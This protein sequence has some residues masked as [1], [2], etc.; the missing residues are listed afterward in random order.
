MELCKYIDHTLLRADAVP[1]E[2]ER[3]CREAVEHRFASVCVNGKYVPLAA[4][5]T[6]GT[7]VGVA[8]VVGFPLGAMASEAKA[9]EA[10]KAVRDGASE[11]DM[12][13]DIG[14][15]K[16][17]DFAA[18]ESDVRAVVRAA[19]G[20]A[21][22]KA[23]IETCLL[24]DDE[25]RAACRAAVAGG[26]AFVKT[27][28]GFSKGGATVEDVRLMREKVGPD[29]GVKASGGVRTR[30]AAEAMIAAGTTRIGTSS[31]A[32]ICEQANM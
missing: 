19:D 2:I 29:V 17:H 8:C 13:I 9:F 30:E 6:A 16:A 18:V 4:R 27:S 23:I 24:T 3:L 11:I 28:T 31:G 26:A 15:A 7:D 12:V 1:E 14:A 25:K 22:V 21:I 32:K 20:C 5:L 10:A